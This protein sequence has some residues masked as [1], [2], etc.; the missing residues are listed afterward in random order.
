MRQRPGPKLAY[1]LSQ[2]RSTT[3]QRQKRPRNGA[4]F[5]TVSVSA[6]S[7]ECVVADAVVV[8]LVSAAQ[9]PA[10]REKNRDIRLLH[11]FLEI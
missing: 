2:R 1:S 4:V 11:S 6:N 5:G 7:G 8:E 9:F 3:I 10:N